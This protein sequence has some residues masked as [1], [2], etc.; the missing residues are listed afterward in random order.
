MSGVGV[1]K[2]CS[3]GSTDPT[4][5]SA[6]STSSDGDSAPAAMPSAISTTVIGTVTRRP[7]EAP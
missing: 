2:A 1:Q 6:A 7:P 5:A 4:L 3:D